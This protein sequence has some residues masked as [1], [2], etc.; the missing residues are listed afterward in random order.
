[1]ANFQLNKQQI[2][3][4]GIPE[5]IEEKETLNTMAEIAAY[6]G[7]GVSRVKTLISQHGLPAAFVRGS[8]FT[9]KANVKKW[10]EEQHLSNV[11]QFAWDLKLKRRKKTPDDIN[12]I[13]RPYGPNALEGQKRTQLNIRSIV[14]RIASK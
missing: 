7:C 4:R 6:M 14:N 11:E 9:T 5:R 10:V 2:V 12:R 13:R 1:M 8:Y 3:E